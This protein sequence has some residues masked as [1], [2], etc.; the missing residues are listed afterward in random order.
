MGYK[1]RVEKRARHLDLSLH[2][3]EHVALIRDQS[4]I[5]RKRNTPLLVTLG[6]RR[7]HVGLRG[8]GSA[9][10]AADQEQARVRVG[11]GVAVAV[12][13]RVRVVVRVRVA[14]AVA[15]RVRARTWIFE[16]A[17]P[18][19]ATASS[20]RTRAAS[21]SAACVLLM[22]VVPRSSAYSWT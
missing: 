16:V 3:S 7:R 9:R 2:V 12:R 5:L 8:N 11:L 22:D 20:A 14:M 10:G 19:A 13:V 21:S 17:S 1:E 15:V 6:Q 4:L 18:R